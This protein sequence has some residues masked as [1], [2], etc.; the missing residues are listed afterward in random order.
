MSNPSGPIP[1]PVSPDDAYDVVVL[2]TG[3]AGLIAAVTAAADGASVGLFEKT[4]LV[5]GTSSMSGGV[6]WIPN[7]HHQRD[8]GLVDSRDD[9]LAYLGAL[10]LG[11]IDSDM[12]AMFVDTAPVMLQWL[13]EN[14]PCRFA[15]IDGY[16][17]Y[18]P[19][20]PGGKPEGGRSLDNELQSLH[21]LGTWADRLRVSKPRPVTLRE[22][23]L[24]GATSL[25]DAA[26]IADRMKRRDAGMG[27]ALVTGLLA[28]CL[29]RAITPHLEHQ[30]TDLL[31]EVETD[32]RRRVSG[33]RFATPEG[34]RVVQARHGVIIATGGFECDA[35]L[36]RTY[37][38]GPMTAPA[39]SP[40]STGDG[41]RMAMAAGAR[42]G[43]MRNAWWVPVARADGAEAFGAPAVHLVL[44][45]RT[46][47][48]SIMVNGTG[49]RFC[50]EATNYNALG[51][52]FHAFDPQTF[53]YPNQPCW[54]IFD[55]EHKGRYDVAGAPAGDQTPAWIKTAGT[56]AEL[57]ELLELNPSVLVATV[58]RFNKFASRGEDPDFGRGTSAYDRFNGDLRFDGVAATLGPLLT[59]PFHAIQI[60]IGALGTSGGPKTDT[61]GRVLASAGGIIDGLYAAG[62]AMAGPTGMVYGGAGGTLGPALTF[63]YIA[64]RDAAGLRQNAR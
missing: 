42:L 61:R 2:G 31:V 23:P 5:G 9:A 19:E 21:Q 53:T 33:V 16:S 51:G 10:S 40:A 52:A 13:E 28:A 4:D 24:G 8:A 48:R 15:V 41:L 44:G 3:A 22:T 46:R 20:H 62:N 54:L 35:D 57:A 55:H 37:L 38:R 27:V 49:K 60:E 59:A 47:P 7:N 18:H 58:D 50:N 32:N 14:T 26:H 17:D 11:Q 43:N 39:G 29:E 6:V 12:A 1:D 30:A 34:E 25:P 56:M 64:G 36:V 63:G 45:E